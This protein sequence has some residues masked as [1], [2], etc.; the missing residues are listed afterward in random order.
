MMTDKPVVFVT[1]AARNIGLAVAKK[2]AKEGYNVCL[3]SRSEKSADLAAREIMSEYPGVTAK[4]YAMLTNDV[5][6]IRETFRK[7]REDFG[8]VDALVSNAADPGYNQS[9]LSTTPEQFDYVMSSNAKGYF[10]C[11]QEAAKLMIENGTHGSIVLVG[12]VHSKRALPNRIVYASSKGAIDVMNRNMCYELGKYGIRS[13]L[14]VVGAVYN[15]RWSCYTPED[16]EK[17]RA[18]WPLGMESYP[19][20]IANAVY[21]LS[22]DSAKTISGSELTVD[23]G[24]MSV[25]LS[26]NKNWDAEKDE[27]EKLLK[28]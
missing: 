9:I 21:F 13:N 15:D 8:R 25:L 10:F 18:N 5:N 11:C 4:G 6:Q 17:K 20:D 1:G 28:K 26:Y 3:T 12:S 16:Y 14:L 2:F 27:R 23:S 24:V 7:V 19:E 22:S